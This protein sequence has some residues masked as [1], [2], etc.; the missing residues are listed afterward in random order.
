M[1]ALDDVLEKEE[2]EFYRIWARVA[3]LTALR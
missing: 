2:I 1:L 3:T